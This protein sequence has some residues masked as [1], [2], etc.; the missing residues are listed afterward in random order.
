M[1]RENTAIRRGDGPVVVGKK[2]VKAFLSRPPVLRFL[3]GV[4]GALERLPLSDSARRRMYLSVIGLHIYRG[5]QA[6]A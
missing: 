1:I 3:H 2:V 5:I 4:V 6:G